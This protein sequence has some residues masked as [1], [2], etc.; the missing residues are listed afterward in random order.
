MERVFSRHGQLSVAQIT[1]LDSVMRAWSRG[2]TNPELHTASL[3]ALA[4][5]NSSLGAVIYGAARQAEYAQDG[6]KQAA[7][8]Q[9][10]RHDLLFYST[11]YVRTVR[12]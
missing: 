3:K 4:Y 11:R 6:L 2:L 10:Q 1:V 8:V 5:R 7:D 9:R 12:C